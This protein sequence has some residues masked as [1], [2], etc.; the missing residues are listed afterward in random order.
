MTQALGIAVVAIP[1]GSL[2][3]LYMSGSD[4]SPLVPIAMSAA[5]APQTAMPCTVAATAA[6]R[7]EVPANIETPAA[8]QAGAHLFRE[9]CV[10]CHGAPGLA[11]TVQGMTPA[12]P[13]L[14]LAG[15]RNDPA[16]V[17]PKIKNGIPG[18]AM[19]AWGDQIPDQ[20]IWALAAFLHHSRGISADA[21]DALSTAEVKPG[22]GAH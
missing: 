2:L 1:A 12:P 16:E 7:V 15:R 17:F 22:E 6:A 11:A 14:L 10:Q 8:E 9:N 4:A 21:F 20:S 13:N 3:F 18:T 19:P 5:C